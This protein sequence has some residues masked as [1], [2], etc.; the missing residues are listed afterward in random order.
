LSTVS[1]PNTGN[2]NTYK[3][4]I[5]TVNL[6]GGTQTLR[7]QSTA[8]PQWKF[9]FFEVY[10]LNGLSGQF[11]KI[12]TVVNANGANKPDPVSNL[13]AA[14]TSKTAIQL[15]WSQTAAP[16]YNETGFEIYQATASGGPFT[17]VAI[18]GANAITY[19]FNGLISGVQYF[20]K[21]RAVNDYAASAVSAVV[22]ATTI[23]DTTAPTTPANLRLGAITSNSVELLW[24]QSKDDVGVFKYDIY[25]NGTRALTT[26]GIRYIVYNLLPS[27]AYT[28]TVLARD[29]AKN[30]SAFSNA[31]TATTLSGTV[32][33]DPSQTPASPNNYATYLNFNLDN[34]AAAPWNNTNVAPSTGAIF[35]NLRN[36]SNNGSG[37]DVTIVN[38]F[39]GYNGNGMTSGIFPTNVMRGSYYC[40]K[41]V[42]ATLRVDGLRLNYKY[43]FIFFGSRDGGGD[44]TS[45]YTIGSQSVSLN[46]SYNTSNTVQIDNVVPDDNG[47]VTIKISLGQYAQFAYLNCLIIK[48]Y[49]PEAQSASTARIAASI[50]NPV[51]APVQGTI[52]AYPN[53]F[54]NDITLSIPVTQQIPELMVRVADVS[55]RIISAQQFKEVPQGIWQQ[56]I[57]VNGSSLQPGVYFIHIAGLPGNKEEVIK[58]MKR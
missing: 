31:V 25:V 17:L 5:A 28:F 51:I 41:G 4:V 57:L 1:I 16:A 34:P 37:V 43:S 47:S 21:V 27:T 35:R 38:N 44:R 11:S 12:F 56:R 49:S 15:K 22:S 40:D 33:Q 8:T 6:A 53:P 24:D 58:V 54:T 55:G 48:G 14:A 39:S 42:S 36:Y 20:Y 10:T 23:P 52:N 30:K 50:D 45:V 46:A 19:T 7:I 3:D 9:N 2:W 29:A 26:S 32:K 18:T 13:T